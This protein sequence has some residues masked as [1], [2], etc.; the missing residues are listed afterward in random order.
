MVESHKRKRKIKPISSTLPSSLADTLFGNQNDLTTSF[1]T[2]QGYVLPD[3]PLNG[4]EKGVKKEERINKDVSESR[5][6]RKSDKTAKNIPSDT[7]ADKC[8]DRKSMGKASKKLSQDKILQ[9]SHSEVPP[10]NK[11]TPHYDD[12][13]CTT[14]VSNLP[15]NTTKRS[16]QRL[17]RFCG[18][19][20]SIR[21]RSF[22]K[23]AYSRRTHSRDATALRHNPT[24]TIFAYVCF[25][26]PDA[27]VRS[28]ELQGQIIAGGN[29]LHVDSCS[30]SPQAFESDSS[31]FVGNLPRRA[32]EQNVI[33]CFAAQGLADIHHVRLVRDSNTGLGQGFGFVAFRGADSAKQALKLTGVELN[34]REL[35]IMKTRKMQKR[36]SKETKTNV[37]NKIILGNEKNKRNKFYTDSTIDQ[38]P[39]QG[40]TTD[41]QKSKALPK[42]IRNLFKKK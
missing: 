1:F 32:S 2:S 8:T 4:S 5:V 23:S 16:L 30:S 38:K 19:I 9:E 6:F 29:L 25:S 24:G 11:D 31:I 40:F 42:R 13:S 7:P 3:L 34:G 41:P 12:P 15:A 21:L 35:R 36:S 20:R 10:E 33:D 27:V 28:L 26:H 39:W 22:A 18:E 17:F 14:F 37:S